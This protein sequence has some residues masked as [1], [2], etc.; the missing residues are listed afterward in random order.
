MTKEKEE[1]EEEEEEKDEEEE[2]E[3]DEEE[4]ES[5][6]ASTTSFSSCLDVF[7]KVSHGSLS[8]TCS[9]IITAI[10]IAIEPAISIF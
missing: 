1:E 10:P 8:I 2:E 3:K 6:F 5:I 4:S 7:S 9:L